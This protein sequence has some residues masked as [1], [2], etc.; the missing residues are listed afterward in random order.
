MTD[1][2]QI[3]SKKIGKALYEHRMIDEGDNILVAVS[4]GKDSMTLLYHLLQK[5][6]RL[7]IRYSIGAVHVQTDFCTCGRKS[8]MYEVLQKWN[9][10]C[11]VLDVPVIARRT[12]PTHE[13]SRRPGA[14]ARGGRN[15]GGRRHRPLPP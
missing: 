5:Q 4:G 13:E 11:A 6:K 2:D 1:W 12:Q 3:I 7:P 8:G 14:Q 10:D 15:R 9:V